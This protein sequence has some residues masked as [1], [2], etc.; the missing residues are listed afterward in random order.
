MSFVSTRNPKSGQTSSYRESTILSRLIDTSLLAPILAIFHSIPYNDL[1]P[2][3]S[4]TINT[5]L[6]IPYTDDLQPI[7]S[8]VRPVTP[9]ATSPSK[10]F[11]K[12]SSMLS[13]QPRRS[14]DS[15]KES[16]SLSPPATNDLARRRSPSPTKTDD[17]LA[18]ASRLIKIIGVFKDEYLQ[19]PIQPDDVQKVKLDE[20][21]PPVLALLL[22]LVVA[23]KEIRLFVKDQILPAS[24]YVTISEPA[25]GSDRSPEAGPLEKRP[26]ILGTI[27][28]LMN[29]VRH[30]S[31][32][33]TAC[34]LIWAVCGSDRT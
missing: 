17:T 7:W 30:T 32:R 6:S 2:P 16:M 29:G 9:P 5:L 21:L 19:Y 31:S 28:R 33:D 27:L 3:L 8:H 13:G 10:K 20:V 15:F 12:L 24:L 23:S 26:T 1:A 34:E 18:V 25:N 22:K 11:E 4:T 14:L